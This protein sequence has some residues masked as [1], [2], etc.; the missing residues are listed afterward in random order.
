MRFIGKQLI[1]SDWKSKKSTV[2]PI[3]HIVWN[4][5]NHNWVHNP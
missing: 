1:Q 2:L 3:R 4:N 5:K